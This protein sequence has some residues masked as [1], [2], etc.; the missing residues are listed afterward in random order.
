MKHLGGTKIKQYQTLISKAKLNKEELT[1]EYRALQ[2][3][4]DKANSLIKRYQGEL[5]KVVSKSNSLIVSEHAMLRYLERVYKLD[6]LKIEQEIA[7]KNLYVQVEALGNGTYSCDESYSAKVVD[8][9]V[10][11][12]LDNK[13]KQTSRSKKTKSFLKTNESSERDI[14]AYYEEEA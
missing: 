10:V 3:K 8:G 5:D 6:L 7:S 4:M 9:V 1:E 13:N 14:E 11:T 2:S 12:I